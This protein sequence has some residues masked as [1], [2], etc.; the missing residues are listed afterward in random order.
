MPTPPILTYLSMFHNSKN[1]F[2]VSKLQTFLE[3]VAWS[4]INMQKKKWKTKNRRKTFSKQ[5]FL[6]LQGFPHLR[7]TWLYFFVCESFLL[8]CVAWWTM[9]NWSLIIPTLASSL[10]SHLKLVMGSFK[11]FS[12][13][14]FSTL[15][16][17]AGPLGKPL[18][19]EDQHVYVFLQLGSNAV[20]STSRD[21]GAT[22][23]VSEGNLRETLM[24]CLSSWKPKT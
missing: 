8:L 4:D 9:T 3:E 11:L 23:S 12:L 10:L 15:A 18:G 21:W 13:F 22:V 20:T 14:H 19:T 5:V 24:H 2:G 6:R 17:L 7:K 16:D 1:L